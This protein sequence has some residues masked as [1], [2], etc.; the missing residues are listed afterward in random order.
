MFELSKAT[1]L[2][3]E[4]QRLELRHTAVGGGLTTV[5]LV[6]CKHNN[7]L[8]NVRITGV[9]GLEVRQANHPVI[10]VAVTSTSVFITQITANS[11][12]GL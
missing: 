4:P 2:C 3:D 7:R 12:A 8:L 11:D 10:L 6:P 1:P 5:R 9:S